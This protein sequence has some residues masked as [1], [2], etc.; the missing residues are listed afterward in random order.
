MRNGARMDHAA[1]TPP[2]AGPLIPPTRKPPANRPLDRPRCSAGTL[3][4]SSVWA[5]TPNIAEPNPPTPRRMMSSANE[6]EN[7]ATMLLTATI[8]MP[9]AITAGW[10]SR[11][12]RRPAGSAPTMRISAN[13]LTTLAAAAVLTPK[14]RANAGISGATI[15]KPSATVNEMAVRIGT[16]RGRPRKGPRGGRNT[17]GILP[18]RADGGSAAGGC[19]PG[20]GPYR[21]PR[22]VL[23]AA[24]GALRIRGRPF[25]DRLARGDLRL[26]VRNH[27]IEPAKGYRPPSR[28]QA[29]TGD[30][31]VHGRSGHAPGV[32][33]ICISPFVLIGSPQNTHSV[34]PRRPP[35]PRYLGA[36]K[37]AALAGI[38]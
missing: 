6:P 28:R 3:T 32:T 26:R 7:P 35:T 21:P 38:G 4:S 30:R 37:L 33:A 17:K 22:V 9:T 14:W 12:A 2:R 5:L 11:S 29:E 18:G 10:P 15:P 23:R 24:L 34:I 1:M 8:A 25:A 16:S 36:P 20:S 31:L 19:G 13:A 27:G